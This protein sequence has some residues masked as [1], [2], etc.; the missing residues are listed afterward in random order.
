VKSLNIRCSASLWMGPLS[1][2]DLILAITVLGRVS[3]YQMRDT[4]HV[5]AR[6]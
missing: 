5:T 1:P 4:P 2:P 3:G 6:N